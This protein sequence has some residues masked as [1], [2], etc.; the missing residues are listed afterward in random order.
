MKINYKKGENDL[1]KHGPVNLEGHKLNTRRDFLSH[2]LITMSTF[3]WMPGVLS[4]ITSNNAHAQV[5]NCPVPSINTKTPVI[6]FDLSGGA[7]I[8]GSN[9]MAGGA[10]GQMDFLQDY[11][12]LGLPADMHPSQAGQTNNELGLVFHNDSPILRGIQNVTN[13]QTRSRIDGALFATSS[14]DDTA[15]NTLNPS[16]WINRAGAKGG[17]SQL[18]GT[19]DSESGGKSVAPMESI[20]PSLRPVQLNRPEDALGLVNIGRLG[21]LFNDTK[22]QRILKAIERMS[23]Q[24]VMSFN[25]QA[26]PDQIKNL[27][28]CGYIGAQDLI[29][30][31]SADAIDA[32]QDAMVN[33]AFNNL[34]DRDQRKT[35]TIAK[36]VLDGHVGVGVVE[37]GGYD[38][39]NKTRATGEIRDF[40]AGELIGRIMT[41][42]NL[43]QK[44]VLIY[45]ITDGGVVA[46]EEIDNSA[47]GRGKYTWTGD[48]G[49]RSSAFML[50]YRHA[51]RATL[52]NGI[53]QIGYYKESGG[54]EN[55]ANPASNSTTNLS[56]LITANFLALHGEEGNLTNVVGDNP[57]G[58][59]LGNYLI[60]QP[61]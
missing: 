12:S 31:Y 3:A 10:G 50:L 4:L 14:S 36:L 39:H 8:P 38:Y 54:V 41:L 16:Y 53:R 43:K 15:N 45:V 37:K 20:D 13:A 46:R 58:N 51:G 24:K 30:M 6:I 19:R 5:A 47:D 40:D 35:A 44:N 11:K 9:V 26:L 42:A 56:K 57:F 17:L 32:S 61:I 7:N 33:Q 22:A 48:S 25:Q 18:A 21:S 27:V 1:K 28:K 49:Q 55:T 52:R 29:G 59:N 2:G 34:N 23:E 60:F